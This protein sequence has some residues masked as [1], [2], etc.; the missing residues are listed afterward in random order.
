MSVVVRSVVAWS[1]R[2]LMQKRQRRIA[3]DFF[4][5][6]DVDKSGGLTFEE[7]EAVFGTPKTMGFLKVFGIC[8]ADA[9]L[10]MCTGAPQKRTFSLRSL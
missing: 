10:G 3:A 6:L 9:W 4:Q 8:A 5:Y 2:P 7:L 1:V